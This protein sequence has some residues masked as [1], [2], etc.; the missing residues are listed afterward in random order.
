MK[1]KEVKLGLE[2]RTDGCTTVLPY[3]PQK[4]P[5]VEAGNK[6]MKTLT[7]THTKHCIIN[8]L[9][10]YPSPIHTALH[11]KLREIMQTKT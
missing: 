8:I 10:Y 6:H 1:F 11:V 2:G 3:I 7:S 9:K 5:K 4:M